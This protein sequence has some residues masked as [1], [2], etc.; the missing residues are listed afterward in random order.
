MWLEPQISKDN[1]FTVVL[2]PKALTSGRSYQ[3]TYSTS[4]PNFP[5][6]FQTLPGLHQDPPTS[7]ITLKTKK[8]GGSQKRNWARR[9]I[10]ITRRGILDWKGDLFP[11]AFPKAKLIILKVTLGKLLFP[12]WEIPKSAF[13]GFV[14]R[15]HPQPQ[16]PSKPSSIVTSSVLSFSTLYTRKVDSLL[17][18][19]NNIVS[20]FNSNRQIFTKSSQV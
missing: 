4:S 6:H 17:D 1:S 18:N 16:R 8:K 15:P 19:T 13:I 2:S 9:N 14:S 11:Q 10:L 20:T 7:F 12:E 3:R 5:K